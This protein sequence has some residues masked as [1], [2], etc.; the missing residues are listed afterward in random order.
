MRAITKLLAATAVTLTMG[1]AASANATVFISFDGSTDV[2]TQ[3]DGAYVFDANCTPA[4]ACG[5]FDTVHVSG[6]TGTPPTLLHSQTVDVNTH[7]TGTA[8]ITIWVTRTG[9]TGPMPNVG[10]LSAFTSNNSADLPLLLTTPFSV[11]MTTYASTSN[12]KYGGTLLST[13]SN[14]SPGA[15]STNLF[16][17][18]LGAGSGP[19]SVTEKYVIHADNRNGTDA[20]TSPSIILSGVAAVPEPATWALMIM[21]FGGA[22]AMLRGQR[23]RQGVA[24]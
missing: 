9:I 5:G 1:A 11:T 24:A 17:P 20:S 6:D 7:H 15:S 3:A 13:F 19:Y 12:A 8:D 21:G 18:T 16:A 4:S 14:S 23:R 22:G 10:F 2:F